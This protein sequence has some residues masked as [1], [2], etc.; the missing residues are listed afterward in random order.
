MLTS[1]LNVEAN[2][3]ESLFLEHLMKIFM[4]GVMGRTVV[5]FQIIRGGCLFIVKSIIARISFHNHTFLAL[6]RS[7]RPQS[8][9]TLIISLYP[10]N[11]SELLSLLLTVIVE[12]IVV[13]TSSPL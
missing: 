11:F 7:V 1:I 2:G 5:T 9:F 8:W 3:S 12:Q 6:N 10:H 13:P 4:R